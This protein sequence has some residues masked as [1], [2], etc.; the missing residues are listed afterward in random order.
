MLS[1]RLGRVVL[2][3]TSTVLRMYREDQPIYIINI[4]YEIEKSFFR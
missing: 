4:H 1:V 3:V 2:K